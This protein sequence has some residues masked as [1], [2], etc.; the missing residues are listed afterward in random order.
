MFNDLASGRVDGLIMS[1][2]SSTQDTGH[3]KTLQ[4]TGIPIVFLT[5]FARILLRIK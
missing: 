1:V 5:G 4:E 3:I 2:A